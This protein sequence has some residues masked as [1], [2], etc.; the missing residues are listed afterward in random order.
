[1]ATQNE[2]LE[3]EIGVTLERLTKQLAQAEARMVKA[4]K[5][6][7]DAFERANGRAAGSF[8]QIDVAAGRTGAAIARIGSG[9]AGAFLG[10]FAIGG[11]V[12][13]F[14]TLDRLV[15][16]ILAFATSDSQD[17]RTHDLTTTS[18]KA[19]QSHPNKES[20]Q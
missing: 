15:E 13:A 18:A 14:D 16:G 17:R 1:M 6:S 3:V 7:E 10:G 19:P 12:Q 8:R 5:R 2:G 9:L 4:A 11:T 20:H